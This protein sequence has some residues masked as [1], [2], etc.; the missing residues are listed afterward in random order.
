MNLKIDEMLSESRKNSSNINSLT[1]E[2]L[3]EQNRYL[4][5]M[6]KKSLSEKE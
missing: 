3:V 4:I 2:E 5:E 6:I 1:I